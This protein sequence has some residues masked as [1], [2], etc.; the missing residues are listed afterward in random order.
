MVLSNADLVELVAFRRHLHQHPELSGQEDWTAAEVAA[1]LRLTGPTRLV[2][3]LGGHG[4]VAVF[5]GAEPGP[6]VMFRCELDALP[7]E[8]CAAVA[9]RSGIAGKGHLCGHDGHMAILL[10][11]ARRLGRQPPRRGRVILLFQPAEEDGSGARAV[12]ADPAFDA[13][14]PDWA[15]ALH[16]M[17]GLPLGFVGLSEGPAN[18][19]SRGVKVVFEG[20]TSHAATPELAATPA[21]AVAQLVPAALNLGPG[22]VLDDGFRLVT[23]THL[24][25]GEPA[26]G[27][28]PGEAEVWLT[29]RCLHD[30]PMAALVAEVQG[31]AMGFAQ[32]EGLRVRFCEHDVFAACANHPQA[33]ACFRRALEGLGMGHDPTTP[34]MRASE[35][36]GVFGAVAKSAMILLGAGEGAPPLHNPDYDFPDDLI[37]PGLRI[38]ERV[39]RDLLG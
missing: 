36:F 4:V 2:T 9:H 20:H 15:F 26:F 1:A 11:L 10:G 24:R 38:F 29:L 27:I 12:L 37:A 3:G 22:G 16:N 8:D 5:D 32:A 30:A 39:L 6:C 28:T 17:P 7:I 14:R 18:C 19:A 31:L 33:A 21:R 25:M 35:D 23:V 13:L 34:P